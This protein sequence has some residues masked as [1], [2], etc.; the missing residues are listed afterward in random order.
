MSSQNIVWH[1]KDQL[2]ET[3]NLTKE[4]LKKLFFVILVNETQENIN[5]KHSMSL[6]DK[7]NY[8]YATFTTKKATSKFSHNKVYQN[9][10]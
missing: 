10:I 6:S 2:W 7:D 1:F 5:S 9:L 3:T 4:G 8:Q